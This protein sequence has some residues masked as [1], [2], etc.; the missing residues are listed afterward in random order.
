MKLSSIFFYLFVLFNTNASEGLT[1]SFLGILSES[2]SP[3]KCSKDLNWPNLIEK[4]DAYNTCEDN[5]L[6]LNVFNNQNQNIL[7]LSQ[8]LDKYAEEQFI[9]ALAKQHILE[10]GCAS[11]FSK[12]LAELPI[13]NKVQNISYIAD[14]FVKVRKARQELKRLTEKLAYDHTI[15]SKV[16]PQNLNELKSR[17]SYVPKSDKFFNTCSEIIKARGAIEGILSTIPLSNI[18]GPIKELINFYSY[19]NEKEV[20]ELDLIKE[21]RKSYEKTSE[22][23][24]K[25]KEELRKKITSKGIDA[26]G[27]NE[28]IM[29]VSDPLILKTVAKRMGGGDFHELSCKMD[30]RYGEGADRLSIY[31]GVGS[32]FAGGGLGV[33]SK[34]GNLGAK[35][36]I[37]VNG[38]NAARA[39]GLISANSTQLLRLSALTSVF[40]ADALSGFSNIGK[41]CLKDI[42]HTYKVSSTENGQCVSAPKIEDADSDNCMLTATLS[43]LG[44]MGGMGLLKFK[45]ALANEKIVKS[46]QTS[47][48]GVK[49]YLNEDLANRIIDE[50]HKELKKENRRSKGS[51]PIYYEIPAVNID[52]EKELS[53]L[54]GLGYTGL[55]IKNGQLLQNINQGSNKIAPAIK[56]NANGAVTFDYITLLVNNEYDSVE[57]L[58][59][60][61]HNVWLKHNKS[62]SG[63]LS[64]RPYVQQSAKEKL[65]TLDEMELIFKMTNPKFLLEDTYLKY[66]KSLINN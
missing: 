57:V 5:R 11:D 32:L 36:S 46:V 49:T 23:L 20:N 6:D 48:S 37:A 62:S 13:T 16:C 35:G 44:F 59:S 58:A 27:R 22:L 53:R 7:K 15:V 40:G 2:A 4:I 47:D 21:I 38:I 54:K 60:D 12:S 50:K 65:K 39:S 1:S 66:R 34:L 26:F 63:Q 28:R 41:T 18:K 24:N 52:I 10:L 42:K 51:I 55:K 31:L 43:S 64:K 61:F 25:E 30:A 3:S 29:L 17:Y 45:L 9:L 19:S 8:G 14:Y 56:N 33:A